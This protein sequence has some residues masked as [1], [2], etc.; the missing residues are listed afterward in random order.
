MEFS[1]VISVVLSSMGGGISLEFLCIYSYLSEVTKEENRSFRFIF[2][3]KFFIFNFS[4]IY[5]N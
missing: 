3:Y 5:N 4:I 2:K 1:S